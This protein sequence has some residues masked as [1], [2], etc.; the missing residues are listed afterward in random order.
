MISFKTRALSRSIHKSG[1]WQ[2]CQMPNIL[3]KCSS[4]QKLTSNCYLASSSF[5]PSSISSSCTYREESEDGGS[6]WEVAVFWEACFAV[7]CPVWSYKILQARRSRKEI[8][9]PWPWT[10]Q[11]VSVQSRCSFSTQKNPSCF[12]HKHFSSIHDNPAS[13]EPEVKIKGS[14]KDLKGSIQKPGRAAHPPLWHPT[15]DE[16]ETVKERC[17]AAGR[18]IYAMQKWSKPSFPS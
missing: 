10:Y 4:S 14:E 16:T 8:W 18:L 17:C 2:L 1:K 6:G 15:P 13:L 7:M 11:W 5:H 9:S 12:K 3:S